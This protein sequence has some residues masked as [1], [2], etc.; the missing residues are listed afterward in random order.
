MSGNQLELMKI[1]LI[2]SVITAGAG[3]LLVQSFGVLGVATAASLGYIV[4]NIWMLL[5]V[6]KLV[7][8]WTFASLKWK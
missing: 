6:R 5:R 2:C 4:K 1:S 8:I 7:G 3:L